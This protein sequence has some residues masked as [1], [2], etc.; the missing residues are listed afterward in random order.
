MEPLDS[1]QI[2]IAQI[3]GLG[4]QEPTCVVRGHHLSRKGCKSVGRSG[5]GACHRHVCGNR[6]AAEMAQFDQ[7]KSLSP[8]MVPVH[9]QEEG[10]SSVG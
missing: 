8:A 4:Q 2:T 1:A 10:L 6:N 3:V 7:P 5:T 9:R